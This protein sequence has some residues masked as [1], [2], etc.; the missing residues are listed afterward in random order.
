MLNKTG[1]REGR[2]EEDN[3]ERGWKDTGGTDGKE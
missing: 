2:R 3:E 1:S